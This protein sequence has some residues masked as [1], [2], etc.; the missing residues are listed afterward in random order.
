MRAGF[1]HNYSD[2]AGSFETG[3]GRGPSKGPVLA[4]K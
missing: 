4:S 1:D 2:Q 3:S